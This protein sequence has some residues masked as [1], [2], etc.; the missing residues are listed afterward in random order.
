MPSASPAEAC[1]SERCVI[2]LAEYAAGEEL[3]KLPC[4]H[5]FHAGCGLQW[6]TQNSK[7]PLC[8]LDTKPLLQEILLAMAGEGGDE[9][10]PPN[11]GAAAP[12]ALRKPPRFAL[13]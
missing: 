2:C 8:Q 3:V 5:A 12:L 9:P 10:T 6:L 1:A 4:A 13:L 7:C 11:A